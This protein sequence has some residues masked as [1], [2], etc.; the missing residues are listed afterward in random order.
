MGE[1]RW[2]PKRERGEEEK[3]RQKDTGLRKKDE[4][5]PSEMK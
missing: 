3:A 1:I 5:D 2:T 4:R